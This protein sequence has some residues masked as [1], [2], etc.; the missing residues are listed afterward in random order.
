[1]L[2][3]C[4]CLSAL[5]VAPAAA[6]TMTS[7]PGSPDPG[8]GKG[9]TL[10]VSFDTANAAGVTDV[11]RGDVITAAGSIGGVRA[12]PAGIGK[13][14]YR[15]IGRGGESLFDFTD[16]TKGQ[17][18]ASFSLYWGSID[19]Y[20]FIDFLDVTGRRV[21]SFSGGDLPSANGNQTEAATNRRVFFDFK[22]EQK[23]TAARLRSDG[24]AFEFDSIGAAGAVPE[25][26]SWA[27]MIIGFG[28][29]GVLA[30]RQKRRV[31]LAA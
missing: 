27:L 8:L 14:V 21:A 12:A 25:P 19:G 11:S 2:L 17:G 15:S 13:S 5:L 30:R 28:A 16:F 22:P 31:A 10:V 18:L 4:L 29:I 3:R 26:E 24:A 23:V 9:E 20:N 1:M 6:V 7:A